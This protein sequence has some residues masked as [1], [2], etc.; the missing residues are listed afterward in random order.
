[1]E[2]FIMYNPTKLHFGRGVTGKLGKTAAGYGKKAL[3]VYGKGSVKKNGSYQQVCEQLQQAGISYVE[4]DGIKSNPIIEDVDQAAQLGKQHQAEMII[5]LGG[6]SVVDSAKII[7]LAMQYEGP[8]W[9][10]MEEKVKP[11]KATPLLAILTLAATGSEM[12]QYA[13]VQNNCLQKKIGYGNRLIYPAHSFL[14]PTFTLSVPAH[15]TAYG[16][17]DLIA[18]ALEAWFGQGEASLSDKFTAAIIKEALQYGP[19]L[20]NDLENYELRA[21]IMYAAT[22]ALNGMTTLGRKSADWG[23]HDIGHC[24]SV[25]FDMP[26]GA[27]LSIAYPA[28]LRLQQPHLHDR[29][30]ELGQALFAADHVDDTIYKLEYFFKSLG[31]PIRLKDAHIDLHQAETRQK[32]KSVMVQNKVSGYAHPMTEADYDKLL[33]FMA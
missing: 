33:D 20:M 31:S 2:N 14:D 15:Y 7:A 10:I 26:H 12:N 6:G 19:E 3:L 27:S 4:Y 8:A 9:D 32:I 1:M 28:W 11:V 16:I 23:T 22:C 30:L 17:V 25:I 18:H 5:A 13:V 24:L 21:K 29:I